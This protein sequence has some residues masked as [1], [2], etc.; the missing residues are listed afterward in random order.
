MKNSKQAQYQFI[1]LLSQPGGGVTQGPYGVYYPIQKGYYDGTGY[2]YASLDNFGDAS[3]A[4]VLV[5]KTFTS[6]AGL[7]KRGTLSP[8]F[9]KIGM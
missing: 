1:L 4:N 6:T 8:T 2:V 7:K 5:G 3:A 9:T